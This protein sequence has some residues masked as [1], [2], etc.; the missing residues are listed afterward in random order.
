MDPGLCI[1]PFRMTNLALMRR[2]PQTAIVI[3]LDDEPGLM[4]NALLAAKKSELP[5]QVVPLVAVL[6]AVAKLTVTVLP[7]TLD[8]VTL[9]VAFA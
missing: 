4:L 2:S 1:Y 6:P 8:K 9:K 7:L 3:G 5:P